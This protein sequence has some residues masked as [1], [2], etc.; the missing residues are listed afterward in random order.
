MT[1]PFPNKIL[2]FINFTPL[3]S[4]KSKPQMSTL[5]SV[6]FIILF[7]Q[8]VEDNTLFFSRF[9]KIIINPF[10]ILKGKG[11]IILLKLSKS[12]PLKNG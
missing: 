8:D 11:A 7:Y 1:L 2:H 4:L 9:I 3:P 10:I 6:C 12:K 5:I